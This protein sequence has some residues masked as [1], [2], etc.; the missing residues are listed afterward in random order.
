MLNSSHVA[1]AV[2]F[3]NGFVS[4]N[5]AA[6]RLFGGGRQKTSLIDVAAIRGS[7]LLVMN[8]IGLRSMERSSTRIGAEKV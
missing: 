5:N 1:A 7:Y 3:E 2:V 4:L 6:K 8:Y